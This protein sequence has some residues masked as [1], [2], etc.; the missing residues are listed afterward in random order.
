MR[1]KFLIAGFAALLL[2]GMSA[3]SRA[4]EST[5]EGLFGYYDPDGVED[6]G[7]I[8]GGA[9][10]YRPND[11]FGFMISAG[12][13]DLEDDFL[14]I[15]NAD[16]QYG[17]LLADLS[18]QWYPTGNNFYLFAGPGFSRID[19]EVDVPGDDNDIKEDNTSF[20]INGGLGYR[21]DIGNFFIRPQVMARWFDEQD[22]E[23][24]EIASYDGLD[25]QYSIGLGWRF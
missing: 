12:V 23:A 16:L 8:Y 20:T 1:K 21:W 25:T 4:G 19:L 18:F 13:I 11:H 10:G 5:L 2:A 3:P 17:L 22:F 9:W 7:Q 6:N 24:D 14:D 15:E